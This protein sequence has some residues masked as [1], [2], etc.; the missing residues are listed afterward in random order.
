M[1]DPLSYILHEWQASNFMRLSASRPIVLN[2]L[3]SLKHTSRRDILMY[4]KESITRSVCMVNMK[5]IH[6]YCPLPYGKKAYTCS[7][8]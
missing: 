2:Q 7:V 3:I 6:P 5:C 1:T 8:N 4:W